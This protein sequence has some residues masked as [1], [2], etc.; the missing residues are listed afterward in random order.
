[1][2]RTIEA[3]LTGGLVDAAAAGDAVTVLGWVKVLA[4]DPVAAGGNLMLNPSA[5]SGVKIAEAHRLCNPM[6]VCV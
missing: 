4:T 1:V 6:L 5:N 3:E 2:P